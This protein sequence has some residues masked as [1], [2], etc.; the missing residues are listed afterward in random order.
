MRVPS[1][2]RDAIDSLRSALIAGDDLR[3]VPRTTFDADHGSVLLMP[4]ASARHV[5]VKLVSVAPDNAARGLP[6]VQGVYV[7]MNATTLTPVWQADAAPLTVLRTTAVSMLGVLTIQ[8]AIGR[9]A[10]DSAVVFGSG[11]QA[12]AH[13][14]AIDELGLA[15]RCTIV[16]RTSDAATRAA[17]AWSKPTLLV[18][19]GN[20]R[21][22]QGAGLVVCCTSAATPLF[23]ADDVDASA[24]VVAIGA[25]T[26]DHREVPTGVMAHADIVTDGAS[27]GGTAGD[28]LRAAQDVGHGLPS[29]TLGSILRGE[30]DVRAAGPW[31]FKTVGEAWQDLAVAAAQIS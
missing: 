19:A 16:G 21:D 20:A 1:Q 2:L 8:A 15:R 29:S 26:P 22:V 28:I 7:L 17:A 25:H 4:A 14:R 12:E 24:V 9:A 27:A 30:A 5:G 11:P 23:D 10:V 3:S 13:V 31:V 18:A 6:R